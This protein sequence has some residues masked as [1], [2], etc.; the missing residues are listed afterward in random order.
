MRAPKKKAIKRVRKK[1]EEIEKLQINSREFG[2]GFSRNTIFYER[3]TEFSAAL[4]SHDSFWRISKNFF[5]MQKFI[6]STRTNV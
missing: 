4:A 2:G 6:F 3:V 5:H 1:T